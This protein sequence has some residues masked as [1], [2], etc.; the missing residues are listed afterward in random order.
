MAGNGDRTRVVVVTGGAM[1]IGAAIAQEC[2]RQGAFVV[3]MD[4]VVTLDGSPE[5]GGVEKTTAERIVDA[6]GT[7]RSSSTSVTDEDA[8]RALFTALVEEFGTLDAVVNVAG[9]S[10]P[11]GFAGGTEEDWTRVL[12]VHLNGYLTVL[13]VALPL[14]AEAGHGRIVGVTSGSGWRPADAG[15]YSCAKRAVASLTWQVGRAA[16]PGVTVNALSPIAATRMVANALARAG[17]ANPSGKTAASGGL[18]LGA[19]PPPEDLGPITAY[20]ASEEF[21]WCSGQIMFSNGAEVSAVAPP[22][23]LEAVRST[24]VSSLAGVVD[25]VVPTTFAAAE[26]A[27][28]SS[29]GSVPR[30]ADA[31]GQDGDTESPAATDGRCLLVSDDADWAG[32]LRDALTAR[33]LTVFDGDADA[34]GFAAAAEQVDAAATDGLDALVVALVGPGS[35]GSATPDTDPPTWASILAAHGG[36]TDAIR[37]DATWVRAVAELAARTERPV[38]IATVTRATSPGGRSRAMSAAQLARVAHS[39][40]ADRVDAFALAVESA[41]DSAR[42]A[43]AELVGHLVTGADAGALSGAELVADAEWIGVRSHP[44]IAGTVVYGGP[45]LPD[46]LDTAVRRVVVGEYTG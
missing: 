28:A 22:H 6:G 12:D 42:A 30:H 21:A 36:I 41:A 39:A 5:A 33:G 27:Q 2:G 17:A 10:R 23:V 13:R 32:A 19:A 8:V 3:T 29:G 45:D 46:W 25:A 26:A 44:T 7:A 24:G 16:P 43:A 35:T 40:T 20:L 38:R 15:A 18:A 9:I 31:F 11:S 34:D 14:M 1:G 37:R 4:P